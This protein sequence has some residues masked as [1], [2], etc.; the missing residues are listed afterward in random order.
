MIQ[1]GRSLLGISVP[2]SMETNV[3]TRQERQGAAQMRVYVLALASL[4]VVCV[5]CTTGG[6]QLL[7]NGEYV[8]PPAAMM[9]RPGPMVDGPGPGVMP[10]IGPG[11]PGIMQ[12][13]F[14]QQAMCP[15]GMPGG[16]G[17]GGFGMG[18]YP[19]PTSPRTS[20]VRFMGPNG[21]AI[22]WDIGGTFAENQLIAPARYNFNQGFTY[23]LKLTNIPNRR[24]GL[25]LYPT[26]QV[27]PSHPTTDGY[28]AH[29][30][31]PVQITDEDLDQVDTNNFV[32]KVVYLPDPQFQ[33]LAID[34]VEEL[35]S[36]RLDPGV[37][38]VHEADRRGTILAVLRIGN[39][40]LEMSGAGAE[41]SQASHAVVDGMNGQLAEPMPIGP[42]GAGSAVPSAQMMG[43][44]SY[45]GMPPYSPVTGFN[46]PQ[47]GH[48]ITA[49][50]IG[51][52]GP[53]SLPLGGPAGLK[54][55]TMR[56]NTPMDIPDPVDHMLVDVKT[57]PG[58]RLPPPVRHVEI[59]EK[60]PL[61]APGEVS[62]PASYGPMG[63]A[64]GGYCPPGQG[65]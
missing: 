47:W 40:D 18:A 4:V 30:P 55:Y 21:M 11:G 52:P 42:I 29:N 24:P 23:R 8:A 13:G 14:N 2:V 16:P 3:S 36:T 7:D 25:S 56:N 38:P 5:G 32:S 15:P 50:P 34:G 10:P 1:A 27:Y 45:P 35:V 22:G 31:V 60:H 6:Q 54:S 41:V 53:P 9:A 51:L 43:G 44:P 64:Q 48:P 49:T 33:D 65:Y 46:A 59:T 58:Y 37:D 20:Q 19:A 57:L 17:M 61:Y 12:A 28:L 63:G 39:V 26:L 62:A